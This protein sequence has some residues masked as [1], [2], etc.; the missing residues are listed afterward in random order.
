VL[1]LGCLRLVLRLPP[2]RN[3]RG[4]R[5]PICFTPGDLYA[6]KG[7]GEG[8]EDGGGGGGSADGINCLVAVPRRNLPEFSSSGSSS[9]A[10]CG[11]GLELK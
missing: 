1:F 8:G 5:G 3:V 6:L 11:G 7:E 4:A 2:V 9:I 10:S